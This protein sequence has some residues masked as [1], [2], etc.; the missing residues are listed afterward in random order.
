M[1]DWTNYRISVID[2]QGAMVRGDADFPYTR[3]YRGTL[4]FVYNIEQQVRWGMGWPLGLLAFIGLAWVIG[5]ALLGRASPAEWVMLAWCVPYFALTGMFMVKFMRYM[6][7]LLPFFG[8]MGAALLERIWR[9]RQPRAM[10]PPAD[11]D[12]DSA[13]LPAGESALSDSSSLPARRRPWWTW[14]APALAL[15][16]L[17]GTAVWALSLI[18]I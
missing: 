1:I 17:I 2:E 8:L 15:V 13:G 6:L 18:H 5:R 3:Q 7:P 4:P 11:S 9:G 12:L 16:V 14:A 10:A